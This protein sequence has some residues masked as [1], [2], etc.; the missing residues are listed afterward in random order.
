MTV[1]ESHRRDAIFDALH[2]R[3]HAVVNAVAHMPPEEAVLRVLRVLI[4]LR[5]EVIR[6]TVSEMAARLG[7][8]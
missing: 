6:E 1:E 7:L 8:E 3:A 5:G 2:S 4:D